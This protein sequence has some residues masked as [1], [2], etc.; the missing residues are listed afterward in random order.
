MERAPALPA[1]LILLLSV[2]LSACGSVID[3][4]QA[5]ICRAVA[6]AL[7]DDDDAT[8]RENSLRPLDGEAALRLSYVVRD[9]DGARPEWIICR[10][11]GTQGAARFDL[12]AVDTERGGLSDVKLYILKR[13]W[14]PEHVDRR[15][16]GALLPLDGHLAYWLQQ[17]LNGM[18]LAGVYGLIATAFALVYGLTR[19]VNLAFGEIA[20]YAGTL[21]LIG[22]GTVLAGGISGI[23]LLL[24]F[25]AGILG[26][27]LMN[28]AL[29]HW[30]VL[31]LTARMRSPQPVLI[32]TVAVG[33]VLSEL[34]RITTPLRENWLPPLM[35]LPMPLAGTAD[36]FIATVTPAQML[37]TGLGFTGASALM[38]LMGFTRFGRDWRAYAQDPQMAELLGVNAPRLTSLSF[39]ISGAAVGLAGTMTV[40]AYGTISPGAGLSL[41]LKALIAAVIG[42][43]GS[44]PGAFLGAILVA[45]VETLW[46][47]TFNIV[48][49]DVVIYSLLIAFLVLRPGGLLNRAAP[50]PREF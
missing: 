47:S 18:T 14:L 24:A 7:H 1:L 27:A 45:G 8:I 5:S 29:G 17:V 48:Y 20:V 13:W 46:S 11:A 42:G 44:V 6:A 40:L 21:M 26:A 22:V 15:I 37:A 49:R 50:T 36:V 32:A 9:A 2:A 41:G 43:I 23:G 3:A 38:A 34:L 19:R 12:S 25:T 28:A 16:M 10:F 31:P 35:N 33:I 39:L 30:V 4:D